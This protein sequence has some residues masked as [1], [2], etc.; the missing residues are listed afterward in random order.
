MQWITVTEMKL[1]SFHCTF[2]EIMCSAG[3][4]VAQ[5]E[6]QQRVPGTCSELSLGAKVLICSLNIKI[7]EIR[8]DF[9]SENWGHIE[10]N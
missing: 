7:F 2:T 9:F 1:Q 10:S 6:I 5:A 4:T 8:S 3:A